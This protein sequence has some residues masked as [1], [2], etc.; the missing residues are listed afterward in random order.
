[1]QSEFV[2]LL[3]QLSKRTVTYSPF[4]GFL[5]YYYYDD[6]LLQTMN[7]VNLGSLKALR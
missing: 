4:G 5:Y 2:T 3:F 1:M 7:S 6:D